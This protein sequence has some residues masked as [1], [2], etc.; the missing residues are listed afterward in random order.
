VEG[1]S[2]TLA[3]PGFTPDPRALLPGLEAFF[4]WLLDARGERRATTPYR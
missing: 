1:T 3:R 2:A 4:E